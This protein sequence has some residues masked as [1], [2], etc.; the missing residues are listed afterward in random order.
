MAQQATLTHA[1]AYPRLG[2]P[3]IVW[4]LVA[5]LAAIA[6]S[7]RFSAMFGTVACALAAI[8]AL[9][10][11][12]QTV[13]AMGVL[14]FILLLGAPG[15]SLFRWVV[16][17]AAFGR[18]I[19]DSIAQS[20]GSPRFIRPLALFGLVILVITP[21]SSIF[22]IVSIFKAVSFVVG[23]GTIFT[24][25]HRSAHLREYWFSWFFTLGAFILIASL[26]LYFTGA[27]Y[28]RNASGFQGILSHPQTY[29]PVLAPITAMMT[30]LYLFHYRKTGLIM[31][32]VLLGL[33]GMYISHARTSLLATILGFGLVMMIGY[34]WRGDWRAGVSRAFAQGEMMVAIFLVLILSV[35][36]W[37]TV[38]ES[39]L[40][41][42]YKDDDPQSVTNILEGSR[43]YLMA[44]SMNNFHSQP[45][46]GI[47]FGVPSD[48]DRFDRRIQTGAFGLPTGASVEKG[49][50]PTAVLE[51]TGIVG[52][53]LVIV[54][55]LALFAPI[56]RRGDIM[57][58]WIAATC[59][60]INFGEM[61]F[62]SLG[63]MGMYFWFV[64]A[65]CYV[66][67]TTAPQVIEYQIETA[68]VE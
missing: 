39:V 58:F 7:V 29:G 53:I 16:L 50:M 17:A 8:H 10:G 18:A 66:L 24:A 5:V 55:L 15:A 63:G 57:L 36:Q 68:A 26:P 19:W 44:R 6:V 56:V 35:A 27:G 1:R 62:F 9:R 13:E 31:A 46:T 40:G 33:L 67:A 41:F 54:L 43:G 45:L 38:Q 37:S 4:G 47:G 22:P 20:A 32:C 2:S 23:V 34:L 65:L 42:L 52:A 60:L 48:A 11:S 51:E 25:L 61:V 21:I 49:F 12:R 30:S 59:V 14:A 3:P 28:T 64:M